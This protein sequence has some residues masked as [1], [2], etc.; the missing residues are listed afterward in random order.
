MVK[1]CVV[2]QLGL[3]TIF[4]GDVC[5]LAGD[6]GY[7]YGYQGTGMEG[8]G[9]WEEE[10]GRTTTFSWTGDTGDMLCSACRAVHSHLT[11][12]Q[13]S[14]CQRGCGR[15]RGHHRVQTAGAG[16]VIVSLSARARTR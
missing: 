13:L 6:A 16:Y 14:A 10:E 7:G 9:D 8:V 5:L 3:V 2:V 4:T 15:A 1:V 11:V 12:L